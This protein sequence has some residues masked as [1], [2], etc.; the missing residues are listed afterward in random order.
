MI[1]INYVLDLNVLVAVVLGGTIS[2]VVPM[3]WQRSHH[4]FQNKIKVID[5]LQHVFSSS[6]RNMRFIINKVTHKYFLFQKKREIDD[7][8]IIDFMPRPKPLDISLVEDFEE[9]RRMDGETASF[10]QAY[11]MLFSTPKIARI[12]DKRN[13][14]ISKIGITLF[15]I[16]HTERQIDGKEIT[17]IMN[18]VDSQI[19]K[20]KELES[21][22]TLEYIR[23]FSLLY[24]LKKFFKR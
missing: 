6:S 17:E 14:L 23:S 4:K 1:S 18:T 19:K 21:E 2:V 12:K 3:L 15:E 11:V 9:F 8:Q 16:C 20:L 13:A 10:S 24:K 22:I 5:E 7:A